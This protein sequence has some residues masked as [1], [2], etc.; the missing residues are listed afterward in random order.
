MCWRVITTDHVMDSVTCAIMWCL[1]VRLSV[2]FVCCV[3]ASKRILRLFYSL[4]TSFYTVSQKN[5]TATLIWHNFTNSQ[6]LLIIFGREGPYSVLNSCD[7]KFLNWLR[8]SCAVSIIT[9]VTWH[10]RTANFWVDFEQGVIDRAVTKWQ[11][12]CEPVS[13][14]KDCTSNTCC[15]FWHRTLLY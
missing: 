4:F 5:R 15:N 3:Q 6:R 9:V 1:S 11:N 13:R 2:T 14:P 10:T 8:T 12:D 7:K